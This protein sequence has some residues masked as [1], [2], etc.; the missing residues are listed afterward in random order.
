MKFYISPYI[1]LSILITTIFNKVWELI[2]GSHVAWPMLAG[3][4]WPPRNP[5]R[6]PEAPSL[7]A[8]KWKCC[9]SL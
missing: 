2:S 1:F 7:A 6:E 5:S 8:P 4:W 3:P 9:F